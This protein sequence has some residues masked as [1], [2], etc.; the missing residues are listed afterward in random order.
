MALLYPPLKKVLHRSLLLQN[1]RLLSPSLRCTNV[2]RN[3]TA[4]NAGWHTHEGDMGRGR[5]PPICSAFIKL[6]RVTL[7]AGIGSRQC[8]KCQ[9]DVPADTEFCSS[10]KSLQPL[11]SHRNHFSILGI[12][13][14]FNIDT[15]ALMRKFKRLQTQYHPDRYST[16]SE[17]EQQF[18]HDHSSAVNK[19]YRCLLHP[20]DRA[21]YFLDLAGQPLEEG[22]IDLDPEFLMAIMEVNEELAEATSKETVQSIGRRN[23]EILNGLLSEADAAFSCNDI[24]KAR[25]VVAKIK[26]YNNIYEKVKSFE[27]EHG[28]VD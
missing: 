22:K 14:N 12:K 11:D 17:R 6:C 21:L 25:T 19:A 24:E 27:R 20:V 28:I 13:M 5:K 4:I 9:G 23:T 10:C 16:K 1:T 18:A 7:S 26:Y 2:T 3:Y 15:Q 8:W